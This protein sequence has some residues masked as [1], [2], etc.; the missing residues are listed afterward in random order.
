MWFVTKSRFNDAQERIAE[1]KAEKLTLAREVERL[2]NFIA[3][4][5]G[6]APTHPEIEVRP[7]W[8]KPGAAPAETKEPAEEPTDPIARAMRTTGSRNP[9]VL[10]NQI[11]RQ[12][13]QEFSR[14]MFAVRTESAETKEAVVPTAAQ[15][16]DV[17]EASKDLLKALAK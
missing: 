8:M 7:D 6:G 11:S 3:W 2:N 15:N 16:A 9:R 13:I 10:A 14:S 4:R 1:L 17:V 12:N 5:L